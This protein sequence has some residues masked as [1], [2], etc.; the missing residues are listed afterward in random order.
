MFEIEIV[1]KF[2]LVVIY[3]DILKK[4]CYKFVRLIGYIEVGGG[5]KGKCR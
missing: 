3:L 5:E 4:I 1:S 2:N